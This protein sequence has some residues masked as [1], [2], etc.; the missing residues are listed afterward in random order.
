MLIFPATLLN[1]I[2]ATAPALAAFIFLSLKEILPLL[3]R[4]IL[5]FT[6]N[7]ANSPSVPKPA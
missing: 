1:T 6:S 3:M 2:T 7:L 5:P 4:A